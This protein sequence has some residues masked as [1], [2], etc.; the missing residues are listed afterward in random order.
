MKTITPDLGAVA[1]SPEQL[2]KLKLFVQ[3]HPELEREI[4]KWLPVELKDDQPSM[5]D[6]SVGIKDIVMEEIT[7]VVKKFKK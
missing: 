6:S 1:L 2:E 4:D 5:H 7:K 3:A